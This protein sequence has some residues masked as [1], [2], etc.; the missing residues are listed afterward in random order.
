MATFW[1]S[2]SESGDCRN[3][4]RRPNH[5]SPHPLQLRI[6]T[7]RDHSPFP[8]TLSGRPLRERISGPDD[9][10]EVG[11][12]NVS[13]TVDSK[14]RDSGKLAFERSKYIYGKRAAPFVREATILPTLTGEGGRPP[15][16]DHRTMRPSTTS[17][18][19]DC[20]T[21]KDDPLSEPWGFLSGRGAPSRAFR[22]GRPKTLPLGRRRIKNWS[23]SIL[24]FGNG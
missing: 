8:Q 17:R 6:R 2:I 13:R 14:A 23:W 7:G 16:G 24:N 9:I 20:W 1:V 3:R 15:R 19:R 11:Y 4:R 10:I 22:V 5:P 21:Q 18:P 12:E